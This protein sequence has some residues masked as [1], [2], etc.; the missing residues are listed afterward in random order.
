MIDFDNEKMKQVLYD[1]IISSSPSSSYGNKH[2]RVAKKALV[3]LVKS[4]RAAFLFIKD[5]EVKSYWDKE[6]IRAKAI[7]EKRV[8][9]WRLYEIKSKAYEKLSDKDRKALNLRKPTQPR[10]KKV[11]I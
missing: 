5:D 1:E 8:E 4:E 11:E 3:E 10:Y 7:I 2:E 6:V 9:A